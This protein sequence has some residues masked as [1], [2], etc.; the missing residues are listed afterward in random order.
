VVTLDR[1]TEFA[2]S[3]RPAS[4]APQ[5]CSVFG[6]W[7]VLRSVSLEG[8]RPPDPPLTATEEVTR[9]LRGAL[10]RHA[11][12]P[13]PAALSGHTPDGRRLTRP[14]AAF[15][16]LPGRAQ[17]ANDASVSGVAIALPRDI[18]PREREAVFQ[19]VAR[20]DQRGLRLVL[21]RL[22]AMQLA[23]IAGSAAD[24]ALDTATWLGPAR[25]WASVTP[26]ALHRNPGKLT[27]PD[28]AV[29]ARAARRAEEIICD[30]CAHVGLPTPARVRIMR[31]PR[32]PG[33]P[34]APEFMPYPR[35]PAGGGRFQRV[36]VHVDLEFADAVE[37]P[38]LLGAGRY[39]G[40]GLCGV[41]AG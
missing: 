5:R 41:W 29:A 15:L 21:G 40:V 18:A 4:R 25:R 3:W 7:V 24:E 32:F 9:A 31:R 28:P 8:G 38:V 23:R 35:K 19:A 33:I 14:H 6:E 20:W 1:G 17:A 12:D 27:S 11:I 10:L 39:F 22:G 13:P 26:I 16:A 34:S 2:A 30:A 37:G 36:C